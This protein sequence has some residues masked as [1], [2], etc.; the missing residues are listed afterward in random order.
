M[1]GAVDMSAGGIWIA[2]IK[3]ALGAS[4]LVVAAPVPGSLVCVDL[5]SPQDITETVS[6]PRKWTAGDTDWVLQAGFQVMLQVIAEYCSMDAVS[7]VVDNCPGN[8]FG[9]DLYVPWDAPEA[10]VDVS[11]AGV[12]PLRNL[13]DVI[14]LVGRRD[15]ATESRILQ[16]RDPRSIRVLVPDCWG[17]DQNFH[18]VTIVDMGDLPESHVSELADLIHKWPPAVINH[19]MWRQRE[20][21]QMRKVAKIK[22]RHKHPAP[23]TFCGT[24]IKTDRYRHVARRHLELAQLWRCPVSWCTVWKGTPQD[25][26]DDIR[27]AHNVRGEIRKVSLEMLFPPW[28]VTRQ[29]YEESLTAQHSGISNDVLLFSEVGLSLVHHYHVHRMGRPHAT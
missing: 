8:T 7:S 28:T 4:Q 17:L 19:I 22:F 18:D 24:I 14:G 10:V 25:L 29:L 2:Y 16:G 1:I 15:D 5:F 21:E 23:C 26:V 27:D 6:F 13:P 12:V 11:S 20:L 9:M 3:Q